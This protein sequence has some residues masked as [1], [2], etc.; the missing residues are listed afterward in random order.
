MWII[1]TLKQ[2]KDIGPFNPHPFL[3]KVTKTYMYII[4][5]ENR[6]RVTYSLQSKNQKDKI[7]HNRP[8]HCNLSWEEIW[9]KIWGSQLG[10]HIIACFALLLSIFPTLLHVLPF[11]CPFYQ[12]C[13]LFCPFSIPF[14][15]LC[16]ILPFC[17]PICR[18]FCSFA[19]Q[20][21]HFDAI[22]NWP[23]INFLDKYSF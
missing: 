3:R 23:K 18:M 16:H 9:R 8:T 6:L 11:G 21:T 1:D 22:F 10:I 5:L 12:L 14:Y 13:C 2:I 4:E 20:F 7:E 19:A 17:H 15:T